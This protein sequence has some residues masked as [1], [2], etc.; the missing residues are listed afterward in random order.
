M[1]YCSTVKSIE[2][3]EE[4]YLLLDDFCQLSLDAMNFWLSK[5]VSEVRHKV[6]EL[7]SPENLYQICCAL[8]R[9]LKEADK[10]EISILGNPMFYSFLATLDV[11]K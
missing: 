8:L 2:K 1:R 3:E 9:L 5:F 11:Q 7:Y 10:S 4:S 6:G